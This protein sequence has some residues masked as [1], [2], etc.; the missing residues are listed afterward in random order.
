MEKKSVLIAALLHDIGKFYEKTDPFQSID[1]INFKYEHSAWTS[2]FFEEYGS[3]LH[4]NVNDSLSNDKTDNIKGIA[5]YHHNPS[6]TFFQKLIKIADCNASTERSSDTEKEY[7]SGKTKHKLL[8]E[9][10]F[11]YIDFDKKNQEKKRADFTYKITPLALTEAINPKKKNQSEIENG[12]QK[13]Y[14]QHFNTFLEELEI[15]KKDENW[16]LSLLHLLEKYLWCVP[17]SAKHNEKQD[18]SLFDHSRVTA[19]IAL[20]LYDYHKDKNDFNPSHLDNTEEQKF[21]LVQGDFSGIQNFIFDISKENA[22]TNLKARSFYLQVLSDVICKYICDELDLH[23]VNI[24]YNGG[25]NFYL[26]IPSTKKEKLHNCQKHI[27]K[28]LLNAHEG[29]IYLAL[30]AL[31][32]S[33]KD[34]KEFSE[35]WKEVKDITDIQKIKKFTEIDFEGVF[36]PQETLYSNKQNTPFNKSF[37]D[38]AEIIL[39]AE[40]INFQRIKDKE[41]KHFYN[42][43]NDVFNSFGYKIN[44]EKNSDGQNFSLNNTDFKDCVGFKFAVNKVDM[45]S[46]IEIAELAKG[47][48]KLALLKMDVDNLGKI[49]IN[50]LKDDERS[51]SRI[52]TLSRSLRIFFEGYINSV[53]DDTIDKNGNLKY[54]HNGKRTIYVIYSG[55]DDTML[56]GSYNK[57]IELASDIKE[58]FSKYVC[59]N[60]LITL[61]ASITIIDEKFPLLQAAHIA[62]DSLSKAKNKDPRKNKVSIFGEIFSWE[63]FEKIIEI[64][65]LLI[66]LLENNTND[67]KESRALLQ[68]INNSTK[69]FK[70]IMEDT[71]K[72]VLNIE[73]IWRFRYYLRNMQKKNVDERNKLIKIYE[74][75][76]MNNMFENKKIENIMILPVAC[77]LTELLT[78]N[79]KGNK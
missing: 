3:L 63:E 37:Q 18:I 17:A 46:F 60:P 41:L 12:F 1:V 35:K 29:N 62:E 5:S 68:K 66:D 31:P 2:K 25:G 72:G 6:N 73:K 76:V 79:R 21:L 8:L 51:I 49:F 54:K 42:N 52:A 43:L 23:E 77:R 39:K 26:L 56:I 57:V 45:R 20:C 58:S 44:F 27:T 38:F 67:K 13:E 69:G 30:G 10:I 50:G 74:D 55:G 14:K 24:L 36:E 28:V 71:S 4:C 22:V 7:I 11:D 47:D 34:F 32:L 9:S 61:T 75:I 70:R 16:D 78:K 59:N 64:K 19:S 48:K 33:F 65:D 15:L 53:I 40:H